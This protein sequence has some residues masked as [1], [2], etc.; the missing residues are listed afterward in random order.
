MSRPFKLFVSGL[1]AASFVATSALAATDGR[2]ATSTLPQPREVGQES[3]F[4]PH[5]GI[6]AG[7][8]DLN[9]ASMTGPAFLLDVGFQ[10][11]VPFGLSAQFQYQPGEIEVPGNDIDFNTTNVLMKGT[12]NFGG[13]TPVIQHSYIGAKTGL[14]VYSGDIES[15]TNFAI[16]PTI[17]ADIPVNPESTVTLGAEAT[18]LGVLGDNSP[19]QAS[20]L[21]AMKYWF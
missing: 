13:T 18:Y 5:V 8:A 17:G 12:Y 1:F 15:E 3:E 9:G 2:S 20:V 11:Y 21:G 16:G 7:V 19:D 14:V 6:M 4:K 10:P